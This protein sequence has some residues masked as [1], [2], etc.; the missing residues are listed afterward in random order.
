MT[1]RKPVSLRRIEERMESVGEGTQRYV[2]LDACR[3]FK[4]SWIEFG[5]AL[6]SVH[7]DKSYKDWNFL[8]FE[9]YCSKELGLRQSTAVKLLKSYA[10]LET[11]DP[12]FIR[13][14]S[15]QS[16][17]GPGEG[18]GKYP[19][20]EAVNLLR[21]VKSRKSVGENEY[22][23]LRRKVLVDAKDPVEVRKEIRLLIADDGKSA[24]EIRADRRT[25]YIRKLARSLEDARREG[26][27]NRFLPA[28]LLEALERLREK[29]DRELVR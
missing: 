14:A 18:Q 29:V 7:R 10:F 27:A 16:D 28:Q 13:R 19:D 1:F 20:F 4:T 26:M 9:A 23:E 11:E 25:A 8:T 17:G 3:K 22:S 15:R 5:Q 12:D 24:G 21:L 6:F 2:V